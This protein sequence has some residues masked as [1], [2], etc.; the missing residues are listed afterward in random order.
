MT[1]AAAKASLLKRFI[2]FSYPRY[3]MAWDFCACN[4]IICCDA[5]DGF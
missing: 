2:G 4:Q 1:L 3:F 5:S